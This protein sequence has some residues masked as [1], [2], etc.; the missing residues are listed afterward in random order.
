MTIATI[1]NYLESYAPTAYAETYDNAGLIVGNANEV[2]TGVICT[3]DAVET[4][5]DEAIAKKANLIVAH[6]PILFNGIKQLN[7][8]NYVEKTIIKAIQNNISIYAIHTNLDNILNGVNKKIADKI[9]LQNIKILLP[10]T[11]LINLIVYAPE[12]NADKVREAIWSVGGGKLG[13]YEDCSF[14][15][16]GAGTFKPVANANPTIGN[17]NERETVNEIAISVVLPYHLKDKALAAARSAHIYEE[18]AHSIHALENTHQFVGSG[19]VGELATAV[20]EHQFLMLLKEKFGLRVIRH[21]A[22]L[23]KTIKKVAICG[24]SGSFLTKNAIAAKADV[25][26][27]ADVK[28]HEFFD[29]NNQL[30]IADIGHWESEQFTTDLLF[31]ILQAKFPNFAVLKSEI[32]TNSIKYFL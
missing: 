1:I 19:I 6:H 17:L 11:N 9:A 21:S 10:K 27:T 7:G 16:N 15:I 2:C 26:I 22:L 24:G 18:V 31:D 32:N 8:K 29:A 14:N 12:D 5:I 30:L 3:L 28:Y 20:S 25:F 13:N 23:E 4:V